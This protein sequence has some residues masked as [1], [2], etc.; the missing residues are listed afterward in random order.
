MFFYAFFLF[1]FSR[2][3]NYLQ[4][5]R[6][7]SIDPWSRRLRFFSCHQRLATDLI[8]PGFLIS[9]LLKASRK[10]PKDEPLHVA[11]SSVQSASRHNAMPIQGQNV[12]S[13]APDVQMAIPA[14][15]HHLR[16]F[17]IF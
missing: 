4:R 15:S 8:D 3:G 6:I 12:S 2:D 5:R 14:I 10:H 1:T 7:V 16:V 9:Y 11:N 13:T 17:I